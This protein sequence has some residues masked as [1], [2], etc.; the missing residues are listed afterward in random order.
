MPSESKRT[1]LKTF[2]NIHYC[3]GDAI[4]TRRQ[5]MLRVVTARDA[6]DDEVRRY[7]RRK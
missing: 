3:R 4:Y 2:T 5:G 1:L 6:E 7:R